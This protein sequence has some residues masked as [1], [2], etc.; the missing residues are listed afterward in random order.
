MKLAPLYVLAQEHRALAERLCDMDVD[1][2]TMLDTLEGEAGALEA[3]AISVAAVARTLDGT[4][5]AIKDAEAS[6]CARRKALET[7]AASL[8]RY[9][10][11]NMQHAGIK[12][13]ECPE[14]VIAVRDNPPAVEVFDAAQIPAEFMRQPEPPPPAPDK[15][16]IKAAI[17][18][19]REVPGAFLSRG[20]RVE[21][22]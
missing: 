6:M 13:V 17:L 11:E 14:F 9:L 21:I 4:A 19:G 2:Q 10:L 8:R 16:A 18:A 5:A 20:Q 1:E 22:K 12:R 3:K 7:R 15:T